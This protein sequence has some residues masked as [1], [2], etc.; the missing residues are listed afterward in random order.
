MTSY[1]TCDCGC[2]IKGNI[3]NGH[4]NFLCL[5]CAFYEV[6]KIKETKVECLKNSLQTL[7]A[8]I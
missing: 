6:V 4:L 5:D 3:R 1:K 8:V 7:K 2:K